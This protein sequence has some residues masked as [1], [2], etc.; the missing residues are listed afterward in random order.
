[1]SFDIAD[2]YRMSFFA[3]SGQATPG[4]PFPDGATRSTSDIG[5]PWFY[6][7]L[8]VYDA[9]TAIGEERWLHPRD[10]SFYDSSIA[11]LPLVDG[12]ISTLVTIPYWYDSFAYRRD[13]LSG[14]EVVYY[15]RSPYPGSGFGPGEGQIYSVDLTALVHQALP[16]PVPGLHC[17]GR[18]LTWDTTRN[19][20]V[21]A[22]ER[23]GLWG[24]AEYR[25]PPMPVP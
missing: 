25:N 14:Q 5:G 22:Y 11:I 9:G 20:L 7:P 10:W 24:V 15:C 21:F 3:N 18:S 4:P 16:W 8:S 1:M 23:E 12:P 19:A 13:A 2:S 6:R 17:R